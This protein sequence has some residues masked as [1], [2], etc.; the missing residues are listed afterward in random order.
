VEGFK[1]LARQTIEL[2][3]LNVLIGANGSGKTA[4]LEAMGLLGA[5]VSGRVDAGELM[6]RGVRPSAPQAFMTALGKA[7]ARKIR[8]DRGGKDWPSVGWHC[9]MS[10]QVVM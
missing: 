8:L 10:S 2:G 3:R 1:S 6:R 7:P 5:A 9:S 4:L